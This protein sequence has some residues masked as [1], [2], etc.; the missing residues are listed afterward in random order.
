MPDDTP[1]DMLHA[2]RDFPLFSTH[3]KK[4]IRTNVKMTESVKIW[5]CSMLDE[6]SLEMLH[7]RRGRARNAAPESGQN[8]NDGARQKDHGE[9]DG[10][11]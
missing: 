7:A 2:C 6:S 3:L 8:K 4:E 10:A 11:R 1:S 5:G 9:N